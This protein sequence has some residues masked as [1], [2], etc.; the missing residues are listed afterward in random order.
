MCCLQ[1]KRPHTYVILGESYCNAIK[2]FIP[3][4]KK[5]GA[6]RVDINETHQEHWYPID[7]ADVLEHV[8]HRLIGATVGWTPQ[9]DYKHTHGTQ[10]G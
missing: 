3:F 7:A 6:Y 9:C 4:L 1:T 8:D 5:S 2:Y 10:K